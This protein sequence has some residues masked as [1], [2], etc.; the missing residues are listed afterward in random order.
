VTT[1][2]GGDWPS[3]VALA[4]ALR[5]R[6][7]GA[8]EVAEHYLDRIDALDAQVGAFAWRPPRE[9]VLADARAAQGV[10]DRGGGVAPFTGVPLPIKDLT[11]VKGEPATHGSRALAKNVGRYDATAVTSLKRA[12]FVLLGRTRAPELGTMPVTEP[13]GGTPTR[14]PWGLAHTAGGSSGG[15]AAAVATGM[16]PV[17]HASDGGGS[18]RIPASAC[19]L[20]GL[21]ASRGRVPKGPYLSE[22]MYGFSTDGAVARTVEDAAALLDVLAH[23]ERDAWWGVT[24]PALPFAAASAERPPR[25]R[26]G[27]TAS[28]PLAATPSSDVVDAVSK[29]ASILATLGHDVRNVEVAWPATPERLTADFLAVWC[30]GTS[31]LD[32]ADW[33]LVEPVNAYLRRMAEAQSTVAHVQ[34]VARLQLFSRALVAHWGRDFDVLLTPTLPTEPPRLGAL[35]DG[36]D[37][38]A[39]LERVAPFVAYVAWVNATG[40]P[41]ITLPMHR[42]PS[43][44]PIGVQLVG[45]PL[46]EAMLLRVARELE[47][48]TQFAASLPV[49]PA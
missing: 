13:L 43:G 32:L 21:K 31:Y 35:T 15:A 3:A 22:I 40:Q 25:L 29:T 12:G 2:R 18:I 19:G 38:A 17:A 23:L 42:A 49:T 16:A 7:V 6:E 30:S 27:V 11:E 36:A 14:N 5:R 28:A 8:V 45:A 41:A 26:V 24:P 39:T 33:S 20:V 48:A 37:A 34:A 9:R 1:A 10:L 46:G 44:L 47:A 4:R